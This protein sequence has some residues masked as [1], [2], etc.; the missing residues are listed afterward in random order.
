VGCRF[1]VYILLGLDDEWGCRATAAQ[2]PYTS[3]STAAQLP[4]NCR[5]TEH[6]PSVPGHRRQPPAAARL[7]HNCRTTALQLTTHL[8]CQVIGGSLQARHQLPH[9]HAVCL[10]VVGGC[11]VAV[12]LLSG[13][14]WVVVGAPH[15]RTVSLP[16]CFGGCRVVVG[17]LLGGL[18]G[19][20]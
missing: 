8:P 10:S 12:M 11:R 7:P 3:P 15:G 17:W 19:G 6:T 2:L 20:R 5:T 14:C 1:R 9:D 16:L 18:G 13:G 4:H